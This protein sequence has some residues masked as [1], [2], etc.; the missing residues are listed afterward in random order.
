M[1]T[2]KANNEGEVEYFTLSAELSFQDVSSS[3]AAQGPMILV[4][5]GYLLKMIDKVS[6]C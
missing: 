2:F 6:Q 1:L 4:A 5:C 3:A